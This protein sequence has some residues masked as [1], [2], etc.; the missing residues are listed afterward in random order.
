MT[1]ATVLTVAVVLAA[2]LGSDAVAKTWA[3]QVKQ[4]VTAIAQVEVKKAIAVREKRQLLESSESKAWQAF[5]DDEEKRQDYLQKLIAGTE[6]KTLDNKIKSY[7]EVAE[8]LWESFRLKHSEAGKEWPGR[9]YYR[10][11]YASL[12][13][14]ALSGQ[15]EG[16]TETLQSWIEDY[17]REGGLIWLRKKLADK[18]HS[19]T[20]AW[21]ELSGELLWK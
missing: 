4:D 16:A 5:P 2:W 15:V 11:T 21:Q 7:D 14:Q 19:V 12:W 1:R 8:E 9:A 18:A 6:A 10:Q 20:R 13:S 3:E 17:Y